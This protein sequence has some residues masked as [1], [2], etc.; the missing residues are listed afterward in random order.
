MVALHHARTGLPATNT[1]ETVPVELLVHVPDAP[2]G[3]A[4]VRL[5]IELPDGAAAELAPARCERVGSSEFHARFDVPRGAH[6]WFRITF[7][8]RV[9]DCEGLD[10]VPALERSLRADCGSLLL[11]TLDTAPVSAR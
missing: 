5:T 9:H 4:H 10:A 11:L 1:F 3:A 2:D 7:T 8:E 6:A